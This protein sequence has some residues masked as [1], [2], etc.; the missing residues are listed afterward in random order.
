MQETVFVHFL[1][2][3]AGYLG[4]SGFKDGNSHVLVFDGHLSHVNSQVIELAISLIIQ[5]F[6]LHFLFSYMT[7]SLEVAAFGTFKKETTS[8]LKTFGQ[9]HGGGMPMKAG[10]VG[11][12]HAGMGRE[13]Y[14]TID[15]WAIP[16]GRTAASEHA[17]RFGQAK[18]RREEQVPSGRPPIPGRRPR[19]DNRE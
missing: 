12:I 17:V 2:E 4:T 6:Q 13:F 3:L 14:G 1:E 19:G 16:G 7:Q 15:Q 8:V 9:R 10:M 11:V 5:L 18:R